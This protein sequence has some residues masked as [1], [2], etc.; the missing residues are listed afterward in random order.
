MTRRCIIPSTFKTKREAQAA[1]KRHY[2]G[3]GAR[4]EKTTFLAFPKG[5][6]RQVKRWLINVLC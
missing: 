5:Q 1:V 2:A 3:L 6:P 4:F